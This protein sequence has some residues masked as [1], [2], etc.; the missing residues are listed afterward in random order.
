MSGMRFNQRDRGSKR[1]RRR[2]VML[3]VG[4][5]CGANSS[6]AETYN[7]PHVRSVVETTPKAPTA[8]SRGE[9]GRPMPAIAQVPSEAPA[10]SRTTRRVPQRL[11]STTPTEIP[12]GFSVTAPRPIEQTKRTE[13]IETIPVGAVTNAA[14]L[15]GYPLDRALIEP[16]RN[17]QPEQSSSENSEVPRRWLQSVTSDSCSE[18][19]NAMLED[20]YREYSVGA[21]ASAE[22]SAWQA[23]EL[24]ATGIDIADRKSSP[25][26]ASPTAAKNLHSA[27]R[28]LIEARD[29]VQAGAAIDEDR[30]SGLSASHS[31]PVYADGPT[32][33]LTATE[34]VDRY[35]D[36]ARIKLAPLATY[37]VRA[38]QAMDL[39]AAIG[40]GRDDES[41]LPEESALCLR[42]A[43]LQGQPTNENLA[44]RLG[45]Q[46]A[47]MGLDAEAEWTL[48]H[49]M[50]I[51]PTPQTAQTLADV[52]QRRGDRETAM[53]LMASL[54]QSMPQQ[55]QQKRIPEVIQL[56]PQQFA[57][58]SP[59][60]NV[61]MSSGVPVSSGK[62]AMETRDANTLQ[63]QTQSNRSPQVAT[64]D[65]DVSRDT[66]QQGISAR[67]AGFRLPFGK[68]ESTEQQGPAP[69]DG[70]SNQTVA[71]Q[72][73][74]HWNQR[75]A[76]VYRSTAGEQPYVVPATPS[77]PSWKTMFNKI[78]KLW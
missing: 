9:L 40:L 20:A 26:E 44:R 61:P 71:K 69:R 65:S 22:S 1:N 19:A 4:V 58:I 53:E 67:L 78:P 45:L 37:Q 33:G 49:A 57:A 46:L 16:L 8:I 14:D 32:P 48:K 18:R 52:M 34:A 10:P 11:P 25:G 35:L 2:V 30:L 5:L 36:Y 27:R 39:I 42:R 24:I 76:T 47:D 70:Q 41:Q 3:A 38:A 73:I 15:F 43:A 50:S 29:F 12:R 23:L 74:E 28:A 59:A 13:L 68:A 54:R 77:A 7:N 17:T 51:S 31:T 62:P 56:S 6:G 63:Q 72:T 60:F 55:Q 21:W 66:N 64:N 75:E